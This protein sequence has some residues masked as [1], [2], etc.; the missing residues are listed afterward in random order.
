MYTFYVI[1]APDLSVFHPLLKPSYIIFI[2]AVANI[3]L[4]NRELFYVYQKMRINIFV[5]LWTVCSVVL[6]IRNAMSALNPDDWL[7]NFL[8]YI[9][10]INYL[11]IIIWHQKLYANKNFIL[12]LIDI[13]LVQAVIS[14]LMIVIRPLKQ[15]A[16]LLYSQGETLPARLQN[17]TTNRIYGIGSNY[18][19]TLPLVQALLAVLALHLAFKHKNIRLLLFSMIL[20]LSSV[21]NNR[22][23]IMLYL[24]IF[25]LYI[26][27]YMI[28]ALT[29]EKTFIISIIFFLTLSVVIFIV[30]YDFDG[31]RFEWIASAFNQVISFVAGGEKTGNMRQ[32]ADNQL[33]FPEG[34]DYIFGIGKRVFSGLT[35]LK[36]YGR[37]SD[38]GFVNDFFKGGLVYVLLIYSST[39]IYIYK[40]ISDNFLS[41]NL[42]FYL[43]LCNYKAEVINGSAVMMIILS[44]ALYSRYITKPGNK[45]MTE[46]I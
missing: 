23:G 45:M 1:Y 18:T 2:F 26:L 25:A 19:V 14:L 11:S 40:N 41:M 29:K 22:T 30:T 7:S 27:K 24:L 32:L 20:V 38:I 8:F 21:L 34:Y 36:Y 17:I 16:N 33:F 10:I 42:L 5:F 12:Y 37:N 43:F 44:V 46:H 35:D 15:I 4:L 13:G 3:V 31:S 9:N 28:G 6:L 39:V